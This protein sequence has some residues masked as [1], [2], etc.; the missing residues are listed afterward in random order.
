MKTKSR[1][2]FVLVVVGLVIVIGILVLF[3]QQTL[4]PIYTANNHLRTQIAELLHPTPT[5][6]PDPVTIINKITALARLETIQYS[7]E[8][9][10][11]AKEGQGFFKLLFGDQLLF[12]AHGKVIAG[13]DLSKLSSADLKLIEDRLTVN[14]PDAEIFMVNLDNEKSTVYDRKTGVLTRA[15]P[16]L[17]TQ[18]RQK[19]ESEILKAAMDDGIL[20]QARINAEAYLLRFFN[21]L[22]FSQ[23]VFTQP[24]PQIESSP[25]AVP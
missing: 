9:I 24:T 21:N 17:E 23:V 7:V 1:H 4:K 22:G 20:D 15:D 8:K 13:V 25:A 18:A 6:L 11:V 3:A 19:A 16:N 14:L 2:V 12:I 10:I 5:I